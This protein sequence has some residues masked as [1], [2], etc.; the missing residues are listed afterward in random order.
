MAKQ[1]TTLLNDT[2]TWNL[3]QREIVV[4]QLMGRRAERAALFKIFGSLGPV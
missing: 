4:G 2:G 3:S 1:S